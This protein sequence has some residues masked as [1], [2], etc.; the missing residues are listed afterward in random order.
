[1]AG[2]APA[3]TRHGY[4]IHDLDVDAAAALNPGH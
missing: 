4:G 3:I 2:Q 1:M